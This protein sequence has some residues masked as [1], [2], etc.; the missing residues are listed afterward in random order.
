MVVLS[1]VALRAFWLTWL[2]SHLPAEAVESSSFSNLIVYLP[3][4]APFS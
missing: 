1:E 3:A 2:G 4:L